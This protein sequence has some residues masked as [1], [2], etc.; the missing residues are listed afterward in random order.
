MR[1]IL[2]CI[3]GVPFLQDKRKEDFNPYMEKNLWSR[4][5]EKKQL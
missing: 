3:V 1:T 4:G 2:E 5:L